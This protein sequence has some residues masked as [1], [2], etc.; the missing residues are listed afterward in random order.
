[1]NNNKTFLLILITFITLLTMVGYCQS[2]VKTKEKSPESLLEEWMRERQKMFDSIYGDD[3]SESM[4]EIFKKLEERF[5]KMEE[6]FK[7]D[8]GDINSF[9]QFNMPKIS[10]E[11]DW[12]EDQNTKTLV[13]KVQ[14]P[15]DAPL[16]IKVVGNQITIKGQAIQE[17]KSN[18]SQSRVMYSFNQTLPI[19][20]DVDPKSMDYQQKNNGS[21]VHLVFKKLKADLKVNQPNKKPI[22]PTGGPSI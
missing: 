2:N 5:F 21:E 20:H 17:T 14:T 13:I 15:K 16:E 7:K 12:I 8:F 6:Q 3:S 22:A 9:G 19:P 18:N 4:D 1:M 11:F 10:E